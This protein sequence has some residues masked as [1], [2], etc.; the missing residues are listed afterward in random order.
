MNSDRSLSTGGSG[1]GQAIA[2]DDNSYYICEPLITCS[3]R[4][5]LSIPA[6]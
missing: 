3:Q 2:D 1:L 6:H 4:A 5:N